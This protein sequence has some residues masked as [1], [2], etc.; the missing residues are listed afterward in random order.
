MKYLTSD[1]QSVLAA[2]LVSP[3]WQ[4]VRQCLMERRPEPPEAKDPSH[5]AAAKGHAR[6]WFEA[7]IAAIEKLPSEADATDENPFSRPAVA[8][9]ED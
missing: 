3:T 5:I 1:S 4:Q 8:F 6:H 7:C 9:T 2:F